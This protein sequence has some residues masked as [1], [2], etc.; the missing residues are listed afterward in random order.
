MEQHNSGIPSV[1]K[2]S[3]TE[4]WLYSLIRRHN[5]VHQWT[6]QSLLEIIWTLQTSLFIGLTTNIWRYRQDGMWDGTCGISE[7]VPY[8]GPARRYGPC[9]SNGR[10]MRRIFTCSPTSPSLPF[11]FA[12]PG[13]T[14]YCKKGA[15]G[16]V[17]MFLDAVSDN[18][19]RYGTTWN[20]R[21]NE[22]R[23]EGGGWYLL[24]RSPLHS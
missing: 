18:E 7:W 1:H 15:G 23:Y 12:C 6:R 24:M 17:E 3:N 4:D 13:W 10:D 9:L 8:M 16:P 20:I 2:L 19:M 11:S 22:M 5:E 14:L 21:D